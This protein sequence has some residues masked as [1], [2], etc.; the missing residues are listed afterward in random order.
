MFNYL[1][2]LLFNENSKKKETLLKYA[3]YVEND[4]KK[5]KCKNLFTNKLIFN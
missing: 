4:N 5:I 2:L 1:I 3:L